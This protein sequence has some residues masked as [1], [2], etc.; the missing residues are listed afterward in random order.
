M[1]EW[2]D[3]PVPDIAQRYWRLKPDS[4]FVDLIVRGVQ[5]HVACISCESVSVGVQ[6]A[7]RADEANHR[8]VN[9]TFAEMSADATNPYVIKHME[10]HNAPVT[11]T[12]ATNAPV[13]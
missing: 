8:D 1:P 9:H 2:A 3:L 10:A 13:V 5:V 4:K 11:K 12:E 6:L 7:I